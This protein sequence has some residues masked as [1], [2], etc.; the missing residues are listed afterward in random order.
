MPTREGKRNRKPMWTRSAPC[1]C[2]NWP[3]QSADVDDAIESLL[4]IWSASHPH[5]G[6][7]R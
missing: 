2:S 3:L 1:R 4:I 6:H 7:L 5:F